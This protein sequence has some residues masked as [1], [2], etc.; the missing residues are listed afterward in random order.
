MK[1]TR[2]SA[3]V[4]DTDVT[5]AGW[6]HELRDLGVSAFFYSVI[7]MALCKSPLPKKKSP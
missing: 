1:L 2:S 5:V 7:A 4:P 3:I 6:V